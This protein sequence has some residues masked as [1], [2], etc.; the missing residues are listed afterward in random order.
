MKNKL[1]AE[2][3]QPLQ[4]QVVCIVTLPCDA[5]ADALHQAASRA[6]ESVATSEQA[7]VE[8]A[9][10]QFVQMA[11]NSSSCC[12]G[13]AHTARALQLGAVDQLLLSVDLKTLRSVDEW[14]ALA[15]ASGA[16]V[17]HV[18]PRTEVGTTFCR[19]FGVGACLRWELDEE[20]LEEDSLQSAQEAAEVVNTVVPLSSSGLNTE[21]ALADDGASCDE[22][23]DAMRDVEDTI[24]L[25]RKDALTTF[26]ARL[27]EALGD[28]TAAEALTASIEVVLSDKMSS[29]EE[30]VEGVLAIA[31]GE[32][33]PEE[34]VLDVLDSW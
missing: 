23:V 25:K 27:A 33:I 4:K 9:V 30:I 26:E 1:Q 11:V 29:R 31:C 16:R 18:H 3:S 2:L 21:S 34:L 17:T 10:K 14:S 28:T 6:F 20:L 7:A 15:E 12:Y 19:S 32:D 5:S 13:E 8:L 24:V 22:D